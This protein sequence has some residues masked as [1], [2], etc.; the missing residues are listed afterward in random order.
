MAEDKTPQAVGRPTAL[1]AML[2][3]FEKRYADEIASW[4]LAAPPPEQRA[5]FYHAEL[6]KRR[7]GP[8]Q[9]TYANMSE[10]DQQRILRRWLSR[11]QN[12]RRRLG[13]A[14]VLH[15]V[16]KADEGDE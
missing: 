8:N 6:G 9:Q 2:A 5:S 12:E 7:R 16:C 1:R 15:E 13:E 11:K 4:T 10:V 3:E 14:E